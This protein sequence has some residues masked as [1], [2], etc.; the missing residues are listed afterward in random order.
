MVLGYMNELMEVA[1]ERRNSLAT[2]KTSRKI[3][4]V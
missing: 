1:V 3:S 4:G 2:F